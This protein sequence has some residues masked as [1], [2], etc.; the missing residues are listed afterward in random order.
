LSVSKMAARASAMK[1]KRKGE[2]YPLPH[3]P[4]VS[5]ERSYLSIDADRS[6]ATQN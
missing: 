4:L 5:K 3:P 1:S 2:M 6:L